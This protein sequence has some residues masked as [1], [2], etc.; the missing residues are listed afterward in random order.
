[1]LGTNLETVVCPNNCNVTG[2][3]S[4]MQ[5]VGIGKTNPAYDLDVSGTIYTSK[6]ININGLTVGRGN[7]SVATNSAF[8]YQAL[9][10]TTEGYQNTAI[11]YQALQLNTSGFNNVAV[12]CYA[13]QK[14]TTGGENTFVGVIAGQFNTTGYCNTF[15]GRESG[16][17]IT[18]GNNNSFLG[19]ESSSS[20]GSFNDSTAIGYK[21][22]ITASNQIMLGTASE[23]VVCPNKLNVTGITTST[24]FNA[25]SDYRIKENVEP[26]DS[27]YTVDNLRPVHYD[28]IKS[29]QHAIGFIAHE[30]QEHYPFLV[31]GEKDGDKTQSLNYNGL[32][33][34]LVNEIQL[35]KKTV[36]EMKTEIQTLKSTQ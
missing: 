6:D 11:G 34:I 24:S 31:D 19:F 21:A 20:S 28:N 9:Q 22:T 2:I 4:L 35:L 36:E 7:A 32:I 13:G 30:V 33:G 18:T 25:T 23:T 15:I 26:L 8:G 14:N 5:K 12:G 10:N 17:N 29:K 3:T 1:M 16:K 27:H